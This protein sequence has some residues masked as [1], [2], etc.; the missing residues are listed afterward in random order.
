MPFIVNVPANFSA[1]RYFHTEMEHLMLVLL[2]FIDYKLLLKYLLN[3]F[4]MLKNV[5]VVL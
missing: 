1:I 4:M 5:I 2:V 3:A